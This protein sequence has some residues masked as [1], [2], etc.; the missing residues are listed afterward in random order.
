MRKHQ[1]LTEHIPCVVFH[2]HPPY[3]SSEI[4]ISASVPGNEHPGLEGKYSVFFNAGNPWKIQD[5]H[6][7]ENTG[8]LSRSLNE[9]KS[10]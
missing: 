10:Q 3:P 9:M 5:L 1:G 6:Y 8:I 2:H 7:P 4:R